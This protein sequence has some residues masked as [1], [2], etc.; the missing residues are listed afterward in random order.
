[1]R[2][3]ESTF[4]ETDLAVFNAKLPQYSL[5]GA[6]LVV[7]QDNFSL[8]E[9]DWREILLQVQNDDEKIATLEA[10]VASERAAFMSPSRILE[11]AKTVNPLI[12]DI[13]VGQLN[14]GSLENE[15]NG[16]RQLI[17]VYTTESLSIEAGNQIQNWLRSRTEQEQIMVYFIPELLPPAQSGSET[18]DQ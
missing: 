8:N 5:D 1:M 10:R 4:N 16:P 12:T 17:T 7:R 13:A 9:E 11:E 2:F 6:E 18:S 15:L 14:Y 3:L